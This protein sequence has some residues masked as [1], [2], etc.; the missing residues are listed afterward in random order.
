MAKKGNKLG[1]VDGL[2]QWGIG[3]AAFA[4][5]TWKA[6]QLDKEDRELVSMFLSNVSEGDPFTKMADDQKRR[7][8]VTVS[9]I[10]SDIRLFANT[11]ASANGEVKQIEGEQLNSVKNH[12]F[13]LLLRNP[14]D[15]M[16][17]SFLW[18]YTIKWMQLKG[19]AYWYLAPRAGNEK[20]IAEA[21]P[22]PADRVKPIPDKEK[23]IRGYQYTTLAGQAKVIR[24]EYVVHFQFPNPFTLLDGEVPLN[25]ALLAMET[26]I[27]TGKFQRDTYVSGRG[28][29]RSIISLPEETGERDFVALSAQIRHDFEEEQKIIITRSGDVKATTLGL[30][31]KEM[32][33]IGQREF[34]R[35]EIDVV[36]LG[37]ELHGRQS[38]SELRQRY[39][40]FQD[41]IIHP[42]HRLIAGQITVQALHRFYGK[43][44]VY[45]F[46]DI[47]TQDR[48]LNVQERNVYFRVNQLREAR[49][50]LNMAEMTSK[51]PKIQDILEMISDLPVP[52]ATDPAFVSALAGLSMQ[53]VGP[54]DKGGLQ[55]KSPRRLASP[56]AAMSESD[57]PVNQLSD[58]AKSSD[59][60]QL[61]EP[62]LKLTDQKHNTDWA[63][64]AIEAGIGTELAR[65]RKVATKEAG[66]GHNPGLYSFKSEVLPT[67][68]YHAIRGGL[69][70]CDKG[71]VAIKAVFENAKL[72][73]TRGGG[74]GRPSKQIQAVNDYQE[75][76]ETE[77]ED[78][79]DDFAGDV[80]KEKDD[81]AR[82]AIIVAGLLVLLGLLQN[83]GRKSLPHAIDIALGDNPPTPELLQLIA[84][85]VA[86]N[87]KFLSES[88]I[89][90]LQ[91]KVEK[92]LQDK[93]ILIALE[94]GVGAEAIRGILGT[95]TARTGQYA[96]AWWSL[97]NYAT[98]ALAEMKNKP[99]LWRLDPAVM[100]HCE[101]C[102]RY[103]DK[104]YPSMKAMLLETGGIS[105]SS[106]TICNGNDRCEL[107]VGE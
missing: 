101:T 12:P 50:E 7:V 67:R 40:M 86:S 22:I 66:A 8:A 3:R 58:A 43:D 80:A 48:A 106:G 62:T 90:D 105:P 32:E 70:E 30:T 100:N 79:A 69:L 56:N 89:P 31:Q 9:W 20:D 15:M 25:A 54:G 57:A 99:I 92:A 93:D 78:W 14:N 74:R 1:L 81:T 52:L 24:P 47:R 51:V 26:E 87:E 46:D 42:T 45:E 64:P 107:I 11:F 13:E 102:L 104:T 16:D 96:G 38:E 44:L 4:V 97:H 84:N 28:M 21:W 94:T 18:I 41:T 6:H 75:E 35:D 82:K 37:Y 2:V 83:L 63:T 36:F 23:M 88:F 19:N 98:G 59:E 53:E 95:M 39:R 10:Y 60:I 68:L 49:N 85:I 72:S 61:L 27:G 73:D 5:N 65:W 55:P 29:P 103:G 34:T 77:Y 33:L 76:L 17:L 71:E 91:A